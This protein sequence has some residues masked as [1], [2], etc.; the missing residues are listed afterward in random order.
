MTIYCIRRAG[1]IS[2]LLKFGFTADLRQ[3]LISYRNQHPEGVELLVAVP[4]DRDLEAVILQL[5]EG[6][7]VAGEWFSPSPMSETL[8]AAMEVV[9]RRRGGTVGNLEIASAETIAEAPLVSE[10]VAAASALWAAAPFLS[11]IPA[12]DAERLHSLSWVDR[13]ALA[14]GIRQWAASAAEWV[15]PELKR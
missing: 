14:V 6:D 2:S 1:G 3:R 5:L 4:G 8:I 11:K 10:S 7:H 9:A 12:D 15:M 13:H